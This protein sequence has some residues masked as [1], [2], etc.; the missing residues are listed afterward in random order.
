MT[1]QDIFEK[2]FEVSKSSKDPR[3]VVTAC[4]VQD[5]SI[6]AAA[7]SSDDGVRHAEDIL[8]EQ[9]KNNALVLN[10]E[11]VLYATLESCNKRSK[12]GMIDCVTQIIDAGIG[13]VVFGARDPLQSDQTTERLMAANIF[14]HQVADPAIVERCAKIF[15]DSVAA[16]HKGIDVDLKPES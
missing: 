4:L 5:G 1:D 11:A 12:E 9:C 14:I 7:A 8:F 15:N 16:E 10:Q 3:G 6:I 2:L 13:S